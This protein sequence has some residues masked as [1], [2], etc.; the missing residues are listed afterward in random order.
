MHRA[1]YSLRVIGERF[2]LNYSA[3]SRILRKLKAYDAKKTGN[4][5]K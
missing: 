5:W 4:P 3:I 2:G 1:G